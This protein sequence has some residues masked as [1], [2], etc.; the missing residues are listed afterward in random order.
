MFSELISL[1]GV[2]VLCV[3][4]VLL[5]RGPFRQY[6]H[7]FAYAALQL[8]AALSQVAILRR[9][10][11]RSTIYM[12]VY[13]LETF[14]LEVLLLIAVVVLTNKALGNNPIAPKIRRLLT[15]VFIA[16][17]VLPFLA[18][19]SPLFSPRWY[20]STAQL[21]TFAV[22]FM[23]LALWTALLTNKPRDP[24]LL[25]VT[26]GLGAITAAFAV[27]FGLHSLTAIGSSAR[28]FVEYVGRLTTIAGGLL[29]CWAFRP[30]SKKK[31]LV[32]S[33]SES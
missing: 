28:D 4:F 25:L 11:T 5:I 16:V 7:I 10:G 15:I 8:F 23:N 17:L 19:S 1:V 20:T 3:V 12:N 9:L 26:A 29:W 32:P 27:I 33:P 13:W 31:T 21:L 18:F 22:A 24:Q 30:I 14:A 6:P 2:L